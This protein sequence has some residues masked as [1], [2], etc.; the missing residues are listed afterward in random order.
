[1]AAL[2]H[3]CGMQDLYCTMKYLSLQCMGSLVADH[4]HSCSTACGILVPWPGMKPT[5]PAL[6]GEFL[7][8]ELPGKSPAVWFWLTYINFLSMV[9]YLYWWREQYQSHKSINKTMNNNIGNTRST[10]SD[11]QW[12]SLN[13]S[14]SSC[15]SMNYTLLK[16]F[17]QTRTSMTFS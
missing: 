2:G 3:T 13:G 15:S 10:V 16:F 4:R 7:N 9:S 8:T 6:Q 17:Q 11:T 14:W 12:E 1:M 5:Y